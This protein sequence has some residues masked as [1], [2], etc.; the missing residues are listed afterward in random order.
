MSVFFLFQIICVPHPTVAKNLCP[1]EP[2]IKGQPVY[3][4]LP[5]T[6]EHS[7]SYIVDFLLIDSFL[8]LFSEVLLS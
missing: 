4:I 6:Q 2:E 8:G 3:Y 7:E 5:E 1:K